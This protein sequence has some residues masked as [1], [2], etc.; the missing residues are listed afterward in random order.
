MTGGNRRAEP[1]QVMFS[2]GIRPG[3]DL[4][5]LDGS[6]EITR[7]PPRRTRVQKRVERVNSGKSTSYFP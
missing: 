3:G 4:T 5:E 6:S 2:D 7:L 1:K